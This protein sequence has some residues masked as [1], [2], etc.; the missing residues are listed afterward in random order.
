MPADREH[1]ISVVLDHD[2]W[3]QFVELQPR[4]VDWL[5]ERILERIAA[6]RV[7]EKPSSGF[8]PRPSDSTTAARQAA[9][10]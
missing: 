5:R 6:S 4:P 7:V 1:V 9:T 2:E 3:T 10:V 8:A